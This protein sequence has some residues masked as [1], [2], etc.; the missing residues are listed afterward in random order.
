AIDLVKSFEGVHDGDLAVI[1]LQPKMC[2]AGIWTVGYGR[3]L[4]SKSTN[5]FLKGASGK[6]EALAKYPALT[7]AQAEEMLAFDLT[8]FED[9]V[10][11]LVKV[12]VNDNQLGALV[13]FAYNVGAGNLASSTLLKKL[14]AK[15]YAGA[16][17]EFLKWDKAG[18][19]ILKGLTLRRTAEMSLFLQPC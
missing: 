5:A 2:P 15:D 10:K 12:D 14:N 19:K 13:S 8:A 9:K 11:A 17:V 18:G 1:G 3:A 16:S 6:A 4:R 7:L